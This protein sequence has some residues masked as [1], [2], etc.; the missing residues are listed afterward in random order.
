MAKNQRGHPAQ[1]PLLRTVPDRN[2]S[3]PAQQ[4]LPPSRNGSETPRNYNPPT[5]TTGEASTRD[6]PS[7]ANQAN[8][9]KSKITFHHHLIVDDRIAVCHGTLSQA[10]HAQQS[11]G[12]GSRAATSIESYAGDSECTRQQPSGTLG[13]LPPGLA[14]PSRSGA[15]GH[16]N[17]S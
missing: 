13:P 1:L 10:L 5:P 6:A 9:R 4:K 15:T 14:R 7:K 2:L 8:G 17:H 16:E 3:A 12:N 11:V